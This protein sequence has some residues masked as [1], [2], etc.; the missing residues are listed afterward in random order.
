MTHEITTIELQQDS[1]GQQHFLHVHRFMGRDTSAGK[2]FIQAALH[3]DE[4]PAHMAA[5]HLLR[6]RGLRGAREN[7]RRLPPH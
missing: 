3:A 5:H 6:Q 4:V 2:V 1:P 7:V